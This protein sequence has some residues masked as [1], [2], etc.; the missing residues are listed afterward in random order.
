MPPHAR[1]GK[2][3][4]SIRLAR[5]VARVVVR[6]LRKITVETI[7]IRLLQHEKSAKD[8][9]NRSTSINGSTGEILARQCITE[10]CRGWPVYRDF[11]KWHNYRSL[12]TRDSAYVWTTWSG[13][14]P[15]EKFIEVS[16]NGRANGGFI[17]HRE[18]GTL[19]NRFTMKDIPIDIN[20]DC[21]FIFFCKLEGKEWKV[22]YVK[23][24]YE[25]D[26]VVPI[27]GKTA[28][29]FPKEE[30]VKYTLR[31][32][33]LAVAQHSLGHPILNNLPNANNEGFRD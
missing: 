25:K 20:C 12:F 19:A 21:R 29:D 28:P 26:K 13:G 2:N 17:A 4:H 1:L 24:F 22:Q 27:N 7:Q 10:L 32:Q 31:Y 8:S 23:L 16:I 3:M 33:Y 18:T 9:N 30:L 14:L 15:I 6:D 5:S 11:S